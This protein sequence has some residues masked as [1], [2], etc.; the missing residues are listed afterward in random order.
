MTVRPGQT[1]TA[2]GLV[3]FIDELVI[4][5]KKGGQI[6]NISGVKVGDGV[7]P[8]GTAVGIIVGKTVGI[9]VG[10][11]GKAVGCGVVVNVG[12]AVGKSVNNAEGDTDLPIVGAIVGP[13]DLS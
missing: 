12:L 8:D 3:F 6:S 13:D 7:G 2:H 5:A 10:S 11:S 1:C 9:N 4:L